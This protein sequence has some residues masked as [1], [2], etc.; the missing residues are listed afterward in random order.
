MMVTGAGQ[1]GQV[2]DVVAPVTATAGLALEDVQLASAG[3]RT[4]VRVVVDLPDDAIGSLDSE[5][6][7]AV[8]RDISAAMDAA[9]PVRGAYVLEVST[10]GTDRPLTQLRHFRRARTRLVRLTMR[11][12]SVVA[13]RLVDAETS[14]LVLSGG[15]GTTTV[16]PADV[17]RGVVEVELSRTEEQEEEA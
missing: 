1:A 3:R 12:G 16:D 2:R 5:A 10:P 7:A 15:A 17:L 11:D 14:G 13:G 9:D 4:V 6:L 8:S